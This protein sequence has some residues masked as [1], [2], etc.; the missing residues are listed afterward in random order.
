MYLD[1][2]SLEKALF[3]PADCKWKFVQIEPTNEEEIDL[4]LHRFLNGALSHARN[5]TLYTCARCFFFFF[6]E[7][8]EW[9]IVSGTLNFGLHEKS[10][11]LIKTNVKF[12]LSPSNDGRT[13]YQLSFDNKN[14]MKIISTLDVLGVSSDEPIEIGTPSSMTMNEGFNWNSL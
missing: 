11:Y 6:N 7:L 8:I 3:K 9:L 14:H 12:S 2:S 1:A 4:K 13:F 10:N 5:K